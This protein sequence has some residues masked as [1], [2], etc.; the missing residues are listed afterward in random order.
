MAAAGQG[1]RLTL[2]ELQERRRKAEEAYNAALQ[3]LQDWQK[4]PQLTSGKRG[5]RRLWRGT[6][7]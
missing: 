2:R 4:V 7:F 6:S 1:G 3:L 5:T